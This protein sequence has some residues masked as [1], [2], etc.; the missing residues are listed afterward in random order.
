VLYLPIIGRRVHCG[1]RGWVSLQNDLHYSRRAFECPAQIRGPSLAGKQKFK[2]AAAAIRKMRRALVRCNCPNGLGKY[3]GISRG[4]VSWASKVRRTSGKWAKV[5]P[6]DRGWLRKTER[7]EIQ[8]PS[9]FIVSLSGGEGEGSGSRGGARA[10]SGRPAGRG[11][12][13]RA[14]AKIAF[15]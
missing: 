13:M 12:R 8:S 11:R 1:G 15:N 7:G 10:S 9:A 5:A 3:A 14:R 6:P 2:A 4:W